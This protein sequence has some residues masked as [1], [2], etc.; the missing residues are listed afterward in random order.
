MKCEV[1]GRSPREGI[2]LYRVNPKAVAG[3]W[4]CLTHMAVPPE[5]ELQQIVETLS[6]RQADVAAPEGWQWCHRTGI[7]ERTQ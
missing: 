2:D 3:I 1:C 7:L 6:N 5:P 4:R